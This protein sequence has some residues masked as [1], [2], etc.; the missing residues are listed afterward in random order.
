[1]E[2]AHTFSGPVAA[3]TGQ[4]TYDIFGIKFVPVLIRNI[5]NLNK[6]GQFLTNGTPVKYFD[7]VPSQNHSVQISDK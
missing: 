4:V 6:F 1:V 3:A 7:E 5:Y 2:V